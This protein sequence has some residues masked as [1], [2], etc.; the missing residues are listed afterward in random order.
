MHLVYLHPHFTYPGG[1][2]TVVLETAKR[3]VK[4]GVKVSIITQSGNSERLKQYP[5]I[6]F[7]FV[8]GPL[9][10][11][12]SYWI[13]YFAIYKRV[14]RILDDISPDIIFPQVFPANYW[15]FLYKKHNPKVPCLWFCHEPSAFVHDIKIINGL[16]EPMR[17]FAKLSNPFMKYIDKKMI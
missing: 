17:F 10:N 3:L 1:G 8:G 16:P 15:G 9:P 7:E 12:F 4:M 13:Q 2:G 6:H 11:S 14:E 5:E